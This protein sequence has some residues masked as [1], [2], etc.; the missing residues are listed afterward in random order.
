[1]KTSG[2]VWGASVKR[3]RRADVPGTCL[4]ALAGSPPYVRGINSVEHRIR[5]PFARH[6]ARHAAPLVT[7]L[8]ALGCSVSEQQETQLGRQ[9]AS[10]IAA[11]LPLVT[12]P[13]V[14]AY[15][16]ALGDSLASHTN[17]A[18]LDWHF[19][20]V[21]SEEVNAFALPGG[22]V[23]VNR[24]LIE[25]AEKLDQL[26]GTLA[27]E[28]GHV[29][30][31]HSVQQM[32]QQ[33][34]ARVGVSLVCTLTRAC[35][36]RASQAAIDVAGSAYFARHSR[37]DEAQADSEAVATVVRAGISPDGVPELF[38]IL[39]AERRERPGALDA[40]F[41]SHPMEEDRIAAT[42]REIDAL[43]PERLDGLLEDTPRFHEFQARVAALPPAP[44]P[45][46]GGP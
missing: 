18:D 28:I 38:E 32:T 27:H 41:A 3:T 25:R 23:Y 4:A 37:R 12:D 44:A 45:A 17:R 7:A 11:Q 2:G 29:V 19:A 36:S 31:R 20:V 1:M 33:T 26:A 46:P 40:F 14:V 22:Y 15:V 43:P 13:E 35:D 34:Q 21:N 9:S 6:V 5:N 10:E 24:G 42:R 30:R 8:L 16:T 39:M